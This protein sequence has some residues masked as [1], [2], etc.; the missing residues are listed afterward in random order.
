VEAIPRQLTVCGDTLIRI[1]L[2]VLAYGELIP[3]VCPNIS[4]TPYVIKFG[5]T[6]NVTFRQTRATANFKFL[7]RQLETISRATTNRKH[8]VDK[9]RGSVPTEI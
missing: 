7:E 6:H 1:Y 9:D 5:G 4:D 3:E 8:S 2:P